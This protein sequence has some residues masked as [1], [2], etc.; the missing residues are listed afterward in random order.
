AHLLQPLGFEL[1]LAAS[2]EEALALLRAGAAPDAILMDLAMPGIDGWE[3]I[4]RLRA[5]GLAPAAPVA[6][7]S[8]NA[9]DKALDNDLGITAADF[10]VKPVRLPELLDWL[11]ARLRLA[12]IEAEPAPTG[13]PAGSERRPE[14]AALRALAGLVRLGHVRG[15]VTELERL[16]AAEPHCAV[17]IARARALARD[18]RLD[19]L[20]AQLEEALQAPTPDHD[21]H[22][23]PA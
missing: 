1:R 8:A 12:W 13:A 4:R 14:A 20:A 2:G 15:I 23:H 10:I 9:F 22:A 6:I 19:A 7:V 5:E 11:G 17:F 3:T 16:E 21:G 18:F